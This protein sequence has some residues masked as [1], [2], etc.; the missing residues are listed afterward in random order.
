MLDDVEIHEAQIV[1]D[2]EEELRHFEETILS[3][4]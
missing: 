2:F 1:L 3:A 4:F